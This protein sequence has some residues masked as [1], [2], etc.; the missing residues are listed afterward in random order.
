LDDIQ[1]N[2]RESKEWIR[3]G[4][5]KGDP[6]LSVFNEDIKKIVSQIEYAAGKSYNFQD[7]YFQ[8]KIDTEQD[9]DVLKFSFFIKPKEVIKVTK[10]VVKPASKINK[11]MYLL[12]GVVV[13]ALVE[14]LVLLIAGVFTVL[15][16]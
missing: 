5:K 15:F 16:R 6:Y 4:S 10:K 9:G 13:F 7:E 8:Y 3:F 1:N 14:L 2:A 11:G 12:I